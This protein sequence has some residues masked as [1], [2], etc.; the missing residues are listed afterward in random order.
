MK[1]IIEDKYLQELVDD[2]IKPRKP[3][4]PILVEK[5][6]KKRIF[7]IQNAVNTNDLRKIKS[8][9]FE[10]LVGSSDIHYSIRVN[11]GWRIIF[12]IENDEMVE[13]LYIEEI[14]NHYS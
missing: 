9:H 1:I 11:I 14:N 12:R 10:K 3:K 5:A 4:F 2:R 7:Q 8:L 13:V 6:F